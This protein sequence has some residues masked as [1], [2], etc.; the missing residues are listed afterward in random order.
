MQGQS[1]MPLVAGRTPAWRNE[2]FYE[3]IYEHGGKIEPCTGVRGARWKY[4]RYY[5]QRPEYEQLFD[6]RNDPGETRNLA[7][8]KEHESVLRTMRKRER[9]YRRELR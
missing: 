6:L 8:A 2:W 3:H 7:E 5:K 9:A 1:L 4:I